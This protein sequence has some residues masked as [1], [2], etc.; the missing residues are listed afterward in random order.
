MKIGIFSGSFD[1]I[2]IGHAMIASYAAQWTDL[3][4]VWLMV[5]RLNPLKIDSEPASEYDRFEMAKIVASG[6]E[7][8]RPSDFELRLPVPSY[9]YRTL[10]ELKKTYPENDFSLII[11]SDNWLG[12]DR[13]RNSWEIKREFGIYIYERPG[14]PVDPE[15]LPSGVRLI[16]GAPQSLISSTFVRKA[17]KERKDLNFFLPEKVFEYVKQKQLYIR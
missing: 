7:G 16:E 10:T 3:D 2:H 13:W 15:T 9:S 14:F 4:E 12:F 11:G 8:V 5:S 6:C 17:L 1:P